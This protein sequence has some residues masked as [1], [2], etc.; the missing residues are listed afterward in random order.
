M[1]SLDE[2]GRSRVGA[3]RAGHLDDPVRAIGVQTLEQRV[4]HVVDGDSNGCPAFRLTAMRVPMK[5]HRRIQAVDGLLEAARAE[6][7]LLLAAH[8]EKAAQFG[9]AGRRRAEERFSARQMHDGYLRLYEEMLR[10]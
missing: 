1:S 7:L 8:P 2:D 5:D 3:D 9:R 10:G 6:K 4:R